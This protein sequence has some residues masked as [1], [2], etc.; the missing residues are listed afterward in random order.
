[1][2]HK[3]HVMHRRGQR[4]W[5]RAGLLRGTV[6]CTALSA[7][8]ALDTPAL[9]AAGEP[10][11]A[12]IALS[13]ST[14]PTQPSTL[15]P[16]TYAITATNHGPATATSA[17]FY[18]S[19]PLDPI[20]INPSDGTTCER[21]ERNVRC[22]AGDL[23]KGASATVLVSVQPKAAGRL[24][25]VFSGWSAVT[26]PDEANDEFAVTTYVRWGGGLPASCSGQVPV[27]PVGGSQWCVRGFTL[28]E[29]TPVTVTLR[30]G[31]GFTG[32]LFAEI[33]GQP[34]SQVRA[35]YVAG[36]LTAGQESAQVTLPAGDWLLVA[37]AGE[38]IIRTPDIW[39]C[40]NPIYGCYA[41]FP[42]PRIHIP[43]VGVGKPV[44]G[45][46]GAEVTGT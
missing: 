23:R 46:F 6:A 26:D 5:L 39:V 16:L 25:A 32:D 22:D 10:P 36:E 43:S 14:T 34:G 20:D 9:A 37:R 24:T 31:P 33:S 18:A 4:A 13:V 45:P 7:L 38:T 40:I 15:E 35:T 17:R 28:T 44:A 1:M 19:F 12:D 41:P 11:R 21:Y 30:P 27:T 42:W 3:E 2:Q 29:Q 8:C